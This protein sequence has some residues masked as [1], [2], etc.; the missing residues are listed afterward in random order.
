MDYEKNKKVSVVDRLT[1]SALKTDAENSCETLT[2]YRIIQCHIP[3]NH[4]LN[5]YK[6]SIF[7]YITECSILF[8]ATRNVQAC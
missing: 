3:K 4:S 2:T 1:E 7:F 6:S 5:F 8:H